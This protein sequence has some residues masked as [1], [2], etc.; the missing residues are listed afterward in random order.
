MTKGMFTIPTIVKVKINFV[1]DFIH[2]SPEENEIS[3]DLIITKYDRNCKGL[4]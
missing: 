4:Q 2:F 1:A 3:R